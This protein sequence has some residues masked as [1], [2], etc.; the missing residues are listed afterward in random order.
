M[1]GRF[2][3][4]GALLR[5]ARVR[6]LERCEVVLR[7]VD[8]C[9]P[10]LQQSAGEIAAARAVVVAADK[11]VSAERFAGKPMVSVG[12]SKALSVEAA[13]ALID[14]ALAAKADPSAVAIAS[15]KVV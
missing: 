8:A 5:Y 14:R 4:R 2:A 11:D 7:R 12:V 3:V 6:G 10:V 1:R 13:G 9:A 15:R